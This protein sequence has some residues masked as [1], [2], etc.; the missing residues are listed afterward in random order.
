VE[1][2]DCLKEIDFPL[3]DYRV[4]LFRRDVGSQIGPLSDGIP[5]VESKR[6]STG[7]SEE[8]DTVFEALIGSGTNPRAYY[9][10]YPEARCHCPLY[11]IRVDS[12]PSN[13]K[14]KADARKVELVQ[15]DISV[16]MAKSEK[17]RLLEAR[18]SSGWRV[19]EDR[20]VDSLVKQLSASWMK[21]GARKSDKN[22]RIRAQK[23]A[24]RRRTR[25]R[26]AK[27]FEH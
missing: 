7:S 14:E 18:E 2:C 12:V 10:H 20:Q 4:A 19:L 6:W 15:Y 1:Q 16:E 9:N 24:D 17:A 26:K 25:E 8:T 11:R 13:S 22:A 3:W 21:Q 27:D 5:V 23:S